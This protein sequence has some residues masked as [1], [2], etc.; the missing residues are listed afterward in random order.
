MCF[1][2][3]AADRNY[4]RASE[5]GRK[6]KAPKTEFANPLEPITYGLSGSPSPPTLWDTW[7]FLVLAQAWL[8]QC[9]NMFLAFTIS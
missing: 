1:R 9:L 4:R 8:I 2:P 5:S 6:R 3:F 7:C